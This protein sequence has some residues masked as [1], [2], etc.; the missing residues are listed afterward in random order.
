M[1][2]LITKAST[3]ASEKRY[4]TI[5]SSIEKACSA[6][7]GKFEDYMDTMEDMLNA[8]MKLVED[9]QLSFKHSRHLY[10]RNHIGLQ[11]VDCNY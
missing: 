9:L 10:R 3:S 2:A 11:N 4:N 8:N 6:I 7:E 5:G 1:D